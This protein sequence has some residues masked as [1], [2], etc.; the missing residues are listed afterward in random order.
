MQNVQRNRCLCMR[1]QE[2]LARAVFPQLYFGYHRHIT[3]C[4]VTNS[5]LAREEWA[6]D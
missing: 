5:C 2:C 3:E 1:T 4:Y 6:A